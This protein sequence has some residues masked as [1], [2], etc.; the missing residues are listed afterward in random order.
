MPY[1]NTQAMFTRKTEVTREGSEGE[2]RQVR[3]GRFHC[4]VYMV[5]GAQTRKQMMR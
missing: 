3:G 5:E 2:E 4:V 1:K